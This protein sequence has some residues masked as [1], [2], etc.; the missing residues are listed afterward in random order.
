MEPELNQR[1]KGLY[2]AALEIPAEKRDQF[3]EETC[4][5][6]RDGPKLKCELEALLAR[7]EEGTSSLDEPIIDVHNLVSSKEYAFAPGD[8]LI[9]RFRIVRPLGRGGMGEVYEAI[10]LQLGRIAIKTIRS[11]VTIH[12]QQL[13]R[14]KRE[15]QLARR[16]SNPHVCR[17]HEFFIID[18]P[19]G[20]RCALLTMEFLDGITL[21]EK[22]HQSGPLPWRE[23][24]KL[25]LEVCT[26][27]QSIH[28]SE[29]VH[30]DLK[31]RNIM[32]ASRSGTTSAVLMD[33]GIA[34]Q[35]SH[36]TGDS[37]T[38]LTREGLIVGTPSYMSPEQRE[39][40]EV[41]PA[42]DIYSLG[43]V[44]YEVVTGKHPFPE[45]PPYENGIIKVKPWQRPSAI[46]RGV[47][48]RCDKVISKCLEYDPKRRFQSAKDVKLAIRTSPFILT[49]KK[50][51]I[52]TAAGAGGIMVLLFCLLLVPAIG[53]RMRGIFFSSRQKHI[54][55][56]PLDFVNGDPQTQALG[57]GLMD[58]LAG[59]LANLGAA[60]ETLWV[61]PASEVRKRK[62]TDPASA[63]REFGATIV[64]RGSFGRD[65]Q[66]VRLKLTLI[67]P[68]KTREI[69]FVD[70]SSPTGDLAILQDEAVTRLGR[71]MNIS[72]QN[73]SSSL[74]VEPSS[75]AAYEDYLAGLGYFQRNDKPGNIDLAI[76]SL[77]NAV[78]TDP[79]FA[80]A[81]AHLAQ[82]LTMKY[83]LTSDPQWLHQAEV[84]GRRAAEL[85]D[86]VA[87]TYVALGQLHELTGKHELAIQE[88][89]RAVNLDPRD[90]EAL[91][92]LANSFQNAGRNAEAEAA[93]VKAAALRPNDWKGH[94]D[95]GNFYEETGR[96]KDAIP[97][98]KHALEL[99]PD[100]SWLYTNLGMTYMDFDDPKIL[101]DAESALK[102]SIALDPTFVALFDLGFLYA[103]KHQFQESVAA[104]QAALRLN[105]NSYEAWY[106]LSATYEWLKEEQKADFC[107][108]RAIE[109][110]EREVNRNEQ[111]ANAQ[112]ALAALYAK[113]GEKAK[114]R[115]KIQLSLALAPSSEYV[116]SQ[117]ADS[118]ELMGE[119]Q[120]A[121]TSL[122]RAIALGLNW[123][124]I[125]E[126][127][128]LQGVSA[129]IKRS[130]WHP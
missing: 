128:E 49:L 100:N 29:I 61:I 109:L 56:L 81:F 34:R 112:A 93:F 59:E 91:A 13:E 22:L 33:F 101:E 37:S 80:L 77:Q 48:R 98:Y 9:N 126:D 58:S 75:H 51:P 123:G 104:N 11:D 44:L 1:L 66:T 111:N 46:Q 121:V 118:Y 65:D 88:F 27:L 85:D 122:E 63:L 115:E 47:P 73:N 127:P 94:N 21:A 71:L 78:K 25:A 3:V 6:Q 97:E 68:Q 42:S 106:N 7:N 18:G 90:T 116:Y 8:L 70:V 24:K 125:N 82:V 84:V 105:E 31:G 50:K 53:E 16:V 2:D 38:A 12:P 124:Q 19:N 52:L 110:L 87:S 57:D 114:A 62:V 5:K 43:V 83:R 36:H 60:N 79:Q 103:E 89:Q 26:A 30:R 54:A 74:A 35:L 39:G 130:K 69:G 23:T 55:V 86:R 120:K 41:T 67:D 108:K 107:R 113:R 17:I 20:T 95:L 72:V 99:A 117:V 15:V 10:D 4:A 129:D 76:T 119:R 102:R 64:V 92:G 45:E 96:P 40:R 28:E 14:F 32:L